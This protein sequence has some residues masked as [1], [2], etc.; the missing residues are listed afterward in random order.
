ML[1]R[2]L[3][4]LIAASLST[5]HHLAGPDDRGSLISETKS[6]WV[7]VLKTVKPAV[8][9]VGS[10]L[11]Q[12]SGFLLAA[13]GTM[14]TNFHVINGIRKV[15]V[16][17]ASGETFSRVHVLQTDESRDLAILRI[18]GADLPF[19]SL[20]NSND[21]SVGE[22]VVLIGAPRGLDQTVSNGIVSSVR[23]LE[24]GTRVIQ[25]TAA[26]S[27]GSS[28]GPL[29]NARGS[30]IGI[31]SFKVAAGENLNFTIPSNYIRGALDAISLTGTGSQ[32]QTIDGGTPGASSKR[33]VVLAGYG[34]PAESFS[35]I[36]IEL[37]NFLT[38]KGVLI[39]DDSGKFRSVDGAE[40]ALP[41]LLDTLKPGSGDFLLYITVDSGY[42]QVD[43]LSVSCYDKAGKRIWK[44]E[45][46][47]AFSASLRG[48]ANKLL[49][50]MQSR[51]EARIGQVGLP[52][53][54]A[55]LKEQ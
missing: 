21:V 3:V 32:V 19:L 4:L 36:L 49:H 51:L 17:L 28:G 54:G 38:E 52:L 30:V 24:T 43:H 23:L 25:T 35:M 46:S 5:G 8:V 13:N 39:A 34:T 15:V 45:V 50:R 53:A 11:G 37:M 14:V 9:L 33:G 12:G 48:A 27:P 2:L 44:E 16:T 18:E 47:S 22:E 31:L 20:A 29:V 1:P 41:S 6:T 7:E 42:G 26:A 10:D 55:A 40:F